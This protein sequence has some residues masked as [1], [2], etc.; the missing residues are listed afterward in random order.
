[1]SIIHWKSN[2]VPVQRRGVS[3]MGILQEE[4]N[5]LFDD[6]FGAPQ[7]APAFERNWAPVMDIV[8][9]DKGYSLHAELP[10]MDANDLQLEVSEGIL[11]LKGE[12]KAHKEENEGSY[13]RRE[14]THGSF[15]RSISLPENADFDKAQA[16]FKNG[17]LTLEV[18][19]KAETEKT[20]K[21]IK[22]QS[23]A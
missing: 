17:V 18:P 23:A 8:E 20:A 19:K 7:S 11:T 12:K 6:L 1:M 2:M 4:I 5:Q 3:P 9:K 13:M 14:T 16:N 21:T 22:I 15:R 10:G